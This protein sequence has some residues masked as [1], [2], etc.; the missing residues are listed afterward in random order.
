MFVFSFSVA[1]EVLVAGVP[2]VQ[3]FKYK[4]EKYSLIWPSRAEFVRHAA[5]FGAP[6]IPF[7]AI[8]AEDGVTTLVD[9]RDLLNAPLLGDAIR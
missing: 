6:I 5:K 2:L 8:G 4:D 7:A 9:G 1:E 3:A